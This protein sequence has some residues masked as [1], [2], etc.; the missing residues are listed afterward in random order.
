MAN[1][2]T[3]GSP[4]QAEPIRWGR[5]GD[6]YLW[7][8]MG[9]H[10]E[11]VPLPATAEELRHLIET[12]F[13]SLTGHSINTDNPVLVERFDHGGMSGGHVS[14]EFWRDKAIPLLLARYTDTE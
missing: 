5:R 10:F 7:R 12:T 3:V 9:R 2:E 4:F 1:P 11:Q 14:A 6:P 8:E 13:E